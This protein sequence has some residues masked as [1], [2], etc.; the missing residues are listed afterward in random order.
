MVSEKIDSNFDLLLCLHHTSMAGGGWHSLASPSPLFLCGRQTERG[1]LS[2]SL[3]HTIPR[4]TCAA[5]CRPRFR[6]SH[7][8][9][10][11]ARLPA[12]TPSLCHS[13]CI[14]GTGTAKMGLTCASGRMK[15]RHQA[16]PQ[17]AFCFHGP[18]PH[19]DS[20]PV[21]Q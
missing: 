18:I 5:F 1:A 14:V 3:C 7:T 6:S 15:P 4:S 20:R 9:Q 17:L 8:F 16:S 21:L 11:A 10:S 12:C 19:T 13:P 2:F